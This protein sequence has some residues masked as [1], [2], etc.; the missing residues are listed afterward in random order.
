MSNELVPGLR[1][2]E[3]AR[4]WPPRSPSRS[5]GWARL[6]A[7]PPGLYADAALADDREEGIW[8]AFL[9]AYLSPLED[10]DDPFEGIRAAHRPWSTG[11][12]PDL[13]DVPLGPRAAHDPKRGAS[14]LTAYRAWAGRAGSQAA[15]L[16]GE[17]A[18][19]PAA[20]LRPRLRAARV[21]RLGR[22]GR[23]EFLVL[24]SWLGLRRSRPA[25]CC[26]GRRWTRRRWPPSASSAWAT[27]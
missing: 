12:L 25:R 18:W 14:T 23:Y 3:D 6:R 22:A 21:A 2:T 11:E 9:I 5:R 15:A 7:D 16:A 13:E 8:L 24:A 19:P 4:A 27:R 1:A 17:E 20:P 26:W 10:A